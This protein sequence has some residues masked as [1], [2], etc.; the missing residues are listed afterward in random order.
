MKPTQNLNYWQQCYWAKDFLPA[1][2]YQGENYLAATQRFS[3]AQ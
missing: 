2:A 1:M 3:K